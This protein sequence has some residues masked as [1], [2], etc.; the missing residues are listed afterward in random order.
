MSIEFIRPLAWV[1]LPICAG[2]V[3]FIDHKAMR[4]RQGIKKRIAKAVRLLLL[5]L[6][7]LALSGPVLLLPDHRAT[8]WA[9]VDLSASVAE[10]RVQ[11]ERALQTGLAN[12]PKDLFTGAIAFGQTAMVDV[13][14]AQGRSG[15]ALHTAPGSAATD[16]GRALSMAMA[17]LPE[18]TAGRIALLSDGKDN[19][20]GVSAQVSALAARG[21]PVDVLAFETGF[22]NDVQV[23]SITT[24]AQ[25]YQNEKFDLVVRIDSLF[26]TTGSLVLY[27]NREPITTREITLRKGENTF[28]FQDTAKESGVVTYEAA[29]AAKG[30]ENQRNNRIGAYMDVRGVPKVLIVGS[31]TELSKMLKAAGMETEKLLPSQIARSAEALRQY[32]AIALVNVNEGDLHA[33]AVSALD[34]Y[35]RKLGRGLAVFGGDDTY[36]IGGWRGSA[37]EEMMPISMDVDNRLQ[38]PS[39]SL[40]LI[41]DKSGS[42]TE[43]R[44]GI[45]KLEMA[46]EAAMRS[47]EVLTNRD[48]VGVIAFDDTAKWAVPM[49]QVE[50]VAAV[51]EM[52]GTI[53]PGGGT[54]FYSALSQ[55]LLALEEADSQLKH[56][57]FLTD[58]EAADSGHETLAAAMAEAGITLT[59]VAVGQGANTRLLSYLAALGGGRAYSTLEFDD[60]PK[61]FTKETYLATRAYLQNRRFVPVVTSG[62]TLTDYAGFPAIDGYHSTTA[63]PLSTVALT[64]DRDEPLLA[65][66]QYGAGRVVA[67]TSDTEGA[68]TG[69]FLRWEDAPRFFAGMISFILPAEEG[70][71]RLTVAREEDVLR[72]TYEIDVFQNDLAGDARI[73]TDEQSGLM[74]EARVLAPDGEQTTI[75]MYEVAPGVYEG[76]APAAM[77]GAYA[78]RVEQKQNNR[79]LRTVES[80]VA[81]G[82]SKEYDLRVPD[83]LPF[84]E[85]IARATGGRVIS[86]PGELFLERG[87]QARARRDLS[88][89]LLWIAL[90]LFVLDVAQR[91]LSWE[92]WIRQTKPVELADKQLVFRERKTKSNTKKNRIENTRK[93]TEESPV[94]VVG[95]KLLANRKKRL[96]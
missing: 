75:G 48:F 23:T 10:E 37:L 50:N 18:D 67:W 41:I 52:I 72:L 25:V 46:K 42:M 66:W 3:L 32:H 91:R 36:A 54:A 84:L 94:T 76:M 51:K 15:M 79:L 22:A 64:T 74:T 68:W 28:I 96:M 65:W 81:V 61:V 6:L 29:L 92:R 60:I 63:K 30:D 78:V 49:Q 4:Q 90:A 26:E 17:L 71:G 70:E 13:P 21:I 73:L 56:V 20:R 1:L 69:D 14:L 58:G 40:V 85:E 45:T 33:D 7:V 27:A 55:A 12:A 59:T 80:G 57:I 24:P 47:A 35:V 82:Y 9:L 31:E 19:G 86:D 34:S 44:F 43:G 88:L 83:G 39:L 16:I 11:M 38:M 77:E 5:F 53:R 89:L 87:P 62:G 8:T 2:L 93:K 95:E